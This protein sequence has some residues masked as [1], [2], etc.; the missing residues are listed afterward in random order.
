MASNI[1]LN[2][3][4][5]YDY[6]SNLPRN[7]WPKVF[8]QPN[9]S[10]RASVAPPRPCL[11]CLP[12]L[13][14]LF[15]TSFWPLLSYFLRSSTPKSSHF[16]SSTSIASQIFKFSHK[17]KSPKSYLKTLT[18]HSQFGWPW[19]PLEPVPGEKGRLPCKKTLLLTMIT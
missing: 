3:S 1:F 16:P 9:F 5:I 7:G 2:F 11:K 15:H 8:G 14:I 10:G 4:L 13:L 17:S 18:S 6:F 12:S 19:H